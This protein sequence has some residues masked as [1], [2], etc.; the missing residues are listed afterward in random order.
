MASTTFSPRSLV[1]TLHYRK[2]YGLDTRYT[3]AHTAATTSIWALIKTANG[4]YDQTGELP[5]HDSFF[6]H[7]GAEA[8]TNRVVNGELLCC[9]KRVA[10]C[11]CAFGVP[12]GYHSRLEKLKEVQFSLLGVYLWY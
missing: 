10:A 9:C 1:V 3:A 7:E 11:F 8:Y 12:L 4:V 6:C 2:N 5:I